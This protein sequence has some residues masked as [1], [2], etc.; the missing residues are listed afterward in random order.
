MAHDERF[1]TRLEAQQQAL[2]SARAKA[3]AHSVR[4]EETTDVPRPDLATSIL[5][6]I[7][8][9]LMFLIVCAIGFVA[10][11]VPH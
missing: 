6:A 8:I 1:N 10:L 7:G 4:H 3:R 2:A 5:I 9:T 11:G